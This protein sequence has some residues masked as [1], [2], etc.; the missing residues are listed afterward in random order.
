ME[1]DWG[2]GSKK[3]KGGG[4]EASLRL[5][6]HSACSCPIPNTPPPAPHCAGSLGEEQYTCF[7]QGRSLSRL[8][9]LEIL[10]VV[11]NCGDKQ[12]PQKKLLAPQKKEA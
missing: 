10:S 3:E 12:S 5:E 2:A 1:V 7:G 11:R 8:L 4:G 6:K 9:G